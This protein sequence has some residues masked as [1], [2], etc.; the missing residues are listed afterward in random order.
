MVSSRI[1]KKMVFNGETPQ[2]S[3]VAFQVTLEKLD[4]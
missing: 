4:S 2:N 3:R 1:V